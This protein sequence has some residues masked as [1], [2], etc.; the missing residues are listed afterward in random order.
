MSNARSIPFR[1]IL[2]HVL[3]I[4]GAAIMLAPFI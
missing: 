2:R 4:A 3:L 1:A